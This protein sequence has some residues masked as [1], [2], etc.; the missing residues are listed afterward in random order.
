MSIVEMTITRTGAAFC[1]WTKV[2]EHKGSGVLS[3][4]IPDPAGLPEAVAADWDR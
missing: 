4:R 2:N 3:R 1:L